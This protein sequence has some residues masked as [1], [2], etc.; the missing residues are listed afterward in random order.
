MLHRPFCCR[1]SG[2]GRKDGS[3]GQLARFI[4]QDHP[5]TLLDADFMADGRAGSLV[6]LSVVEKFDM[7]IC[8]GLPI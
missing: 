8:V 2:V 1:V 5:V 6:D 3:A 4:R 7:N